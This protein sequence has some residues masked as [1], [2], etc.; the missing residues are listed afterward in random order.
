[1]R[2]TSE[3]LRLKYE[4]GLSNRQIARSCGLT[5]TTVSNY[6][7]RVKKAGLCWPLSEE[8]DEDQFQALLF[9]NTSE[10]FQPTR[11]LPDMDRIHKELRRKHVTLRLLWEEYR[12]D[13]PEGY[14]YTQF[15]EYYKRWKSKLDVTLRQRHVAGE[16][17]FVDWA[18]QP[19]KRKNPHT[20]D[21][22][23]AFLFVAPRDVGVSTMLL[24]SEDQKAIFYYNPLRLIGMNG[25]KDLDQD[26]HRRTVLPAFHR[27]SCCFPNAWRFLA[28]L[29]SYVASIDERSLY[30]NLYS[31]AELDVQLSERTRGAV[32]I[33]TAYPDSGTISIEVDVKQPTKL[34]L[35]LRIP[36][37]ASRA[38]VEVAGSKTACERGSYHVIR[39][40]WK[41]NTTVTLELGE[42]WRVVLPHPD[43][44]ANRDQVALGHGPIIYCVDQSDTEIPLDRLA[45]PSS[46]ADD[47]TPEVNVDTDGYQIASVPMIDLETSQSAS[48][49]MRPYYARGRIGTFA[50]WATWLPV[51][52]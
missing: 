41:G 30:I 39:Q 9:P 31:S 7:S 21:D 18:G 50:E 47:F 38:C 23:P 4:V 43:V 22:C 16:K 15:C 46:A 44:D 29:P 1:M 3:I 48:I 49:K 14:G 12:A 52:K 33:D 20:G 32:R 27:T 40:V 2:R 28:N 6:L 19:L 36:Q 10:D 8:L 26:A 17:M 13:C 51:A 24:P 25:K 11:T 35:H 42:S 45:I 5:H 34:D 37:W